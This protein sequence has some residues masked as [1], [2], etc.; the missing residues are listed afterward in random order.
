MP[1]LENRIDLAPEKD[2]F[3]FPLVRINHTFDQDAVGLWN[4]ALDE[5]VE[6][7]KGAG[8]K[9]I[10]PGRGGIAPQ[11]L[12]GGTIM[13]TNASNSVVNSYGQ[14]HRGC[15]SLCGRMRNFSDRKLGQPNLHPQRAVAP[16]RRTASHEL[17]QHRQLISRKHKR[18]A[19]T[20]MKSR[21]TIT[22]E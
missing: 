16:R 3:G 13:G 5:G 15:K 12:L 18:A 11:H 6:I 14:T 19:L 8:A 1:K 22:L 10:W 2:E 21:V 7:A 4:A 20:G 9:E 17:E